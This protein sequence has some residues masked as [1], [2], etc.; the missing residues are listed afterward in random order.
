MFDTEENNEKRRNLIS[1]AY[2]D[3]DKIIND[4]GGM[5]KLRGQCRKNIDVNSSSDMRCKRDVSN[6]TYLT[7]I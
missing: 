6:A 7:L 5:R 3:R 1:Y 4:C 2:Q